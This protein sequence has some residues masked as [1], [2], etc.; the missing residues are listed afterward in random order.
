M[1]DQ[2]ETKA[3][4]IEETIE[5]IAQS[6]PKVSVDPK[7]LRRLDVMISDL[8]ATARQYN[9]DTI[10]VFWDKV[11]RLQSMRAGLIPFETDVQFKKIQP[12]KRS[13]NETTH[14]VFFYAPHEKMRSAKL[15]LF[16][17][18]ELYHL[19]QVRETADP[20]IARFSVSN[21]TRNEAIRCYEANKDIFTDLEIVE[22]QPKVTKVKA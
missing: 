12:V 15:A 1:S 13:P 17:N 18:L 22:K 9:D 7:I 14:Q 10:H 6:Q 8:F 3:A 21:V 16:T 5:K 4:V 20:V 11:T 19:P 2:I